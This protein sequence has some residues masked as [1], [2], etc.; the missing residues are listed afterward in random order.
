MS[1]LKW[2]GVD[3]LLLDP[4]IQDFVDEKGREIA[5]ECGEG[6]VYRPPTRNVVRDRGMV[7]TDT[8]R[9]RYDNAKNF[10]LIRAI[11]VSRGA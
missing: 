8:I 3:E 2:T 4:A 10:T 6:Y 9:A 5:K 11:G 1:K 7:V